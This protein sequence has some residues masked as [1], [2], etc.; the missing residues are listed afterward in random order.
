MVEKSKKRYIAPR[1]KEHGIVRTLT[2]SST[3]N[4]GMSDFGMSMGNSDFGMSM[5]M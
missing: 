5:G 1:L 2:Q 3:G 4:R